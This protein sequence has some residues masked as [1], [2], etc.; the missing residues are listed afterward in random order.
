M[1]LSKVNAS[2]NLPFTV[3]EGDHETATWTKHIPE[4]FGLRQAIRKS[5]YRW[6]SRE[7]YV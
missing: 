6:C 2:P 7:R 3:V 5:P 1:D 4:A